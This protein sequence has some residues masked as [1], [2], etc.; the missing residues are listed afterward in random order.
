[1][2][3]SVRPLRRDIVPD[4]FERTENNAHCVWDYVPL[5]PC[6]FSH[7]EYI[8]GKYANGRVQVPEA[9]KVDNLYC[10]FTL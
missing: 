2:P 7:T 6:W 4:R 10:E 5:T 9:G 1:M 8:I 3:L